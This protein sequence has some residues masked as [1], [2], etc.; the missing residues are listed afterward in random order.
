MGDLV[1]GSRGNVRTSYT[2]P[3]CRTGK[4][5]IVQREGMKRITRVVLAMMTPLKNDLVVFSPNQNQREEG[6]LILVG[7][8]VEFDWLTPCLGRST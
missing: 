1:H 6:Q 5:T 8:A 4:H 7:W 3:Q 2:H